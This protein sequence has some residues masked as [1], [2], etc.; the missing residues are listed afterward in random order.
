MAQCSRASQC[1]APLN[2]NGDALLQES[3]LANVS[4]DRRSTPTELGDKMSGVLAPRAKGLEGEG[5]EGVSCRE[6]GILRS[7]EGLRRSSRGAGACRCSLD[8][9]WR[10]RVGHRDVPR[11]APPPGPRNHRH[12]IR[13]PP[14][15]AE[16]ARLLGR[17]NLCTLHCPPH[18]V[19]QEAMPWMSAG[20]SLAGQAV[21]PSSVDLLPAGAGVRF[22]K[23]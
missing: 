10:E 8:M 7:L 13:P 21:S 22:A 17:R 16:V 4:G 19:V 11:H 12:S 2:G 9:G 23:V 20:A 3:S 5:D 18:H 1:V 15:P 14:I 6:I